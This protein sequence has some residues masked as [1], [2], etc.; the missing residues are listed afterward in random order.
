MLYELRIYECVPG[1][2]ARSDEALRH[3]HAE[4]VGKA[5]H[6]AGRVLDHGDRRVEPDAVLSSWSGTRSQSARR[7]GTRSASIRN[8]IKAR[9]ETEKN[10]AIVANVKNFILAPTA[11]SAVK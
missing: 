10:G 11:F 5:W 6:Q 9:A 3:H 2:A 8:G 4:A 7:S 1:P